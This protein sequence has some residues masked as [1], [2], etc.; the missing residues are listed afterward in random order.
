MKVLLVN[1]SSN[2]Q[3]CTYTALSEIASTLENNGIETEIFQLGKDAIR[4]C[5]GCGY[6]KKNEGCIFKDDVVR[7]LIEKAKTSDGFIFGSPVYYAHPSGRLISAMDRAF[8]SGGKYFAFKPA[9][10]IVSARRA[11]T[12]A[13]LDVITK[14]FTINHM[15][16][17]P[18]N[19]WNMVHGAQNTPDDVRKD[20]EGLQTMRTLGN[21]MAWIL[22]C[23]EAGKK[24]GINHPQPE[25]KIR[26]N[27]IK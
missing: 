12:T 23:I 18:S 13:S 25:D 7:E 1:G 10:A 9:T 8:Y 22:K 26:T 21:N 4:D 5:V 24:S 27:F 6:C 17:I 19:Y 11:G 3:G 20:E 14:H 16:V 2:P 15:P